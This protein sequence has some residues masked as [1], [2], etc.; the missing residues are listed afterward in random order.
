[1]AENPYQPREYDAV[2]GGHNLAPAGSLVLGGIEGVKNR[3]SS[4]VEEQRIAAL[5]DAIKYGEAGLDLVIQALQDESEQV[6]KAAYRLLRERVE[7]RVKQILQGYN[8]WR[9]FEYLPIFNWHSDSVKSIAISPD[10]QTFVSGSWDNT[11]KIWNLHTGELIRT[12]IGHSSSVQSV[13]ITPDGQ[14]LVSGSNDKTIKVW[15]PHT[16]ELI[17]TLVGHSDSVKSV[18]IS[19]DGQT[20]VSGGR[21]GA[22]KVWGVG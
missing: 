9:L 1:M 3:L 10:G 7:P 22:I 20:I 2:L 14:T 13:A 15:N 16:G 19:P 12:L 18:A 4:A 21:D 5:Q 8:P 11:I 17:K 6:E